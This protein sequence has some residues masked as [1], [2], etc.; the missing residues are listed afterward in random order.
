MVSP[1]RSAMHAA[2]ADAGPYRWLTAGLLAATRPQPVRR[3]VVPAARL[4]PPV[5]ADAQSVD[6]K[7]RAELMVAAKSGDLTRA[8]ALLVAG[9]DVAARNPNGGTPLMYAAL[10]GNVAVVRRLLICGMHVH[11]GSA[12]ALVNPPLL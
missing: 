10:G 8:E 4:A 3:V 2:A 12:T 9:A 11:V 7:G 5:F 6:G 1:P